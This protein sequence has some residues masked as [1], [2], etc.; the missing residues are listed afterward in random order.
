MT[1]KVS[2]T[3]MIVLGE[4]LGETHWSISRA[5]R[6]AIRELLTERGSVGVLLESR[7]LMTDS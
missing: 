1:I 3:D 6:A 2:D 5:S 7:R 4:S